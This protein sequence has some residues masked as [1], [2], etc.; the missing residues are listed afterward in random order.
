M[1][2]EWE[3]VL[4]QTRER[5]LD[6]MTIQ[7]LT[8]DGL[9]SRK[10]VL[11]FLYK[12]TDEKLAEEMIKDLKLDEPDESPFS[13][14]TLPSHMEENKYTKEDLVQAFARTRKWC[15]QHYKLD[16]LDELDE[17]DFDENNIQ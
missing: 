13:N 2:Y 10:D 16:K 5:M 15:K 7:W 17:D 9:T 11:E 14:L 4:Y 6:V 8:G 3:S 12:D 1:S